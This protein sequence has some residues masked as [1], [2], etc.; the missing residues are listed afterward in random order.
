MLNGLENPRILIVKFWALGDILMATPL[1]RA[2]RS[3]YPGAYIA[4]LADN[5]YSDILDGNPLLDETIPFDSGQWRRYF[6][7]ANIPGYLK[8][9]R[10]LQRELKRRRFDVVINLT[11]EKWWSIWFNIAPIRI[12]LFPRANP[13]LIGRVYT[14]AIP[15]SQDPWL[16][17]SEHYLLPAEALGI[18]GPHSTQM[19]VAVRDAD[20][21][22]VDRF[23]TSSPIFQANQPLLVLHPGTSQE[24][25]CWPPE[26]F[27]AVAD[28]L[29]GR[30][31]VVVTG[32]P[33][34]RHLAEAI[35]ASSTTPERILVA[36][37]S[38][39][40]MRQTAALVERADA[41][42][43]GDTSVLHMASALD[44]P[45]V[46]VY[47]STRPKD[48]APLFGNNEL[49]FVEE[50][51]CAPCYKSHCPLSGAAHLAC[52]TG[53]TADQVIA[54]LQRMQVRQ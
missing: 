51:P 37:G 50:L 5:R 10:E 17:N 32:S 30:Y 52:L 25:K 42:V 43:T 45:L 12:G 49:L 14:K 35:R 16:H 18:E 53:I 28:K 2:I 31:N 4:W 19:S 9:T 24:T 21:E 22:A 27:A 1:L 26:R 48:N 36:T 6:R 39:A 15:R 46:G 13:G 23:L 29:T 20:R 8:M 7:Y 33:G 34:E 40:D 54:A 44:T 47:G 11:A 41:V 3:K 38:L